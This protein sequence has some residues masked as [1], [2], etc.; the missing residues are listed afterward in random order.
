MIPESR[1]LVITRL[2]GVKCGVV[3]RQLSVVRSKSK[4]KPRIAGSVLAAMKRSFL[5]SRNS[6]SIDGD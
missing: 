2:K 5:G 1:D 4:K 3:A 6:E